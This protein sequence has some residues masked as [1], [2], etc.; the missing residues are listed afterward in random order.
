MVPILIVVKVSVPLF[1]SSPFLIP[2]E[3]VRYSPS[4]RLDFMELL[5]HE[6]ERSPAYTIV[7]MAY[8][9]ML[10]SLLLLLMLKGLMIS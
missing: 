2:R 10:Q 7:C 1:P 4:P 3:L 9:P 6:L 5:V 8:S